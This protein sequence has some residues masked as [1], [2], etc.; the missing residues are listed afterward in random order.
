[1]KPTLIKPV[2]P[3]D[4]MGRKSSESVFF[5]PL[6]DNIWFRVKPKSSAVS[7]SVPSKSN[8]TVVILLIQI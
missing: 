7:A 4:A 1:L 5:K 3:D 6:F 8:N 2:A